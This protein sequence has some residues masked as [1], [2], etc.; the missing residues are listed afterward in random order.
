MFT[1]YHSLLI[2]LKVPWTT[3]KANQSILK[4]INPEFSLKGLLDIITNSMYINLT[5]L[6]EIMKD[7]EACTLQ[8]MESQ[9]VG[10]NLGTEQ[11]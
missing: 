9:R 5:N 11:K 4:E 2:L 6:Q 3:R 10:H 8:P 1:L 7:R